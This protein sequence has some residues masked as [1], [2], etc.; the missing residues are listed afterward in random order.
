MGRCHGLVFVLLMA[1]GGSF[2]TGCTSYVKDKGSELLEGLVEK[3]KEI[4]KNEVAA[5][6][7]G[8]EAK[9]L[10]I[11]EKKAKEANQKSLDAINVVLAQVPVIDVLTGLSTQRTWRDFDADRNELIDAGEGFKIQA[12]VTA[13]GIKRVQAGTMTASTF[14]GLEKDA[15]ISGAGGAVTGAAILAIANRRKK[16]GEAAAAN[17][18]KPAAPPDPKSPVPST[19]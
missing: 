17:P 5:A 2:N 7:P 11:A 10:D 13:E 6:L 3:G 4:V 12:F 18:P 16:R 1:I 19:S 8:I 15:A 14:L 9:L